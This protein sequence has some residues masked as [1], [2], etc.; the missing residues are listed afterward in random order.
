VR[1]LLQ[2]GAGRT[3][4]LA[5]AAIAVFTVVGL[6]VLWP[7]D[8]DPKLGQIFGGETEVAEVTRFEEFACQ[9]GLNDTCANVAIELR[10]GDQ[11]GTESE[12]RD[13][14]RT[15]G[16]I[17][18]GLGVGDEVRVSQVVQAPG[19]TGPPEFTITDYERRT[20]ML[21]LAIAFAALV[22]LFGRLRGALSLLGL[23]ISLAIVL[24]F[25][26]PAI[27]NGEDP[28]WVAVFG[29]LAAMLATISLAHGLN[30]KSVA[31]I[32]GT[33]ASLA[34]VVLLAKLFT[35]ATSL[36]GLSSEE[37]GTLVF[38]DVVSQPSLAGLLLAGMVIGAL[39]VLDDVT[40]SQASTVI[41][42]RSANPGLGFG[43]LYRRAIEV[44]RDHVSATVNT[45]VL[46]YVGSALPVLLVLTSS[47]VGLIEGS[48]LELVAKEIV[49]MLVG[50]IG[51]IAAV[52][53][54]TG[55]TAALAVRAEPAQLSAPAAGTEHAH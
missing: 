5:A 1:E 6:L 3:F 27:L 55:L 16:P 39:G 48:N 21:W 37:A 26:V 25:I 49:A 14:G 23:A 44:G 46:A 22:I 4:A 54:T 29:A 36:T 11:E 28:V 24:A 45:L 31:A 17:P 18:P 53:L 38:N 8:V 20:P 33:T 42:L 32:L 40:V 10:S 52:P 34:L 41:A 47:E 35:E 30:A 51:L 2:S 13:L 19:V 9:G 43:Q 15:A 7:G 12:I 50:S